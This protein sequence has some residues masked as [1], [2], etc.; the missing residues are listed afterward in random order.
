MKMRAFWDM[1]PALYSKRL[2]SS[3]YNCFLPGGGG[4]RTFRNTL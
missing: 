4:G 2:S 1:A 3:R